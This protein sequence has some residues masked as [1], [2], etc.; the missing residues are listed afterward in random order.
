[1]GRLTYRLQ[2]CFATVCYV[3]IKIDKDPNEFIYVHNKD[4]REL[5]TP[6]GQMYVKS[7]S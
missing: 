5:A 1:M 2:N 3:K 4:H 7:I 6:F